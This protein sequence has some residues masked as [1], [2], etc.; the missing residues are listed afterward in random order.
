MRFVAVMR[1]CSSFDGVHVPETFFVVARSSRTLS[2]ALVYKQ[3]ALFPPAVAAE[4]HSA[5]PESFGFDLGKLVDGWEQIDGAALLDAFYSSYIVSLNWYFLARGG[6][7]DCYSLFYPRVW[8]GE[9]D[10]YIHYH[11]SDIR[12]TP[13]WFRA[14]TYEVRGRVSRSDWTLRPL[15]L[16]GFVANPA[17][18]STD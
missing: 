9:D 10:V 17:F 4:R 2:E 15:D 7:V 13:D 8:Q 1:D 6:G 14:Q 5:F 16:S 11:F 18:A 3:S 12:D